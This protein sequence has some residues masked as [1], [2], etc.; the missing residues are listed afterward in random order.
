MFIAKPVARTLAVAA[1]LLA[2]SACDDKTTKTQEAQPSA[3]QAEVLKYNEYIAAANMTSANFG[4]QLAE[5]QKYTQPAF[6]GK[7]KMDDLFFTEPLS[8]RRIKEHLDK[9]HGMKPDMPELDEPGRLYSEALAK[10]EP[11][12][13][14]MY[15][16]ISAKTYKS[17]NGAHGREIQPA[18]LS[19]M[20]MLVVAQANF[21][22]G[23]EAK[24][25]ARIKA[26]FERTQ[27]GTLEH[28][29]MGMV[30]YLKE[31]LDAAG[32]VLDGKGLGDKKA[33]FKEAL[34]QFNSMATAYDAKVR[35]SNKTGCSSLLSKAN[36]YL[37]T[38][39][40]I[41]ERTE[42]GEYEKDAKQSTQF[43]LMQSQQTQDAQSLLQNYNNMVSAL[44]TNQC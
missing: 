31:S 10:A 32:G 14:D 18:L 16:Y 5:Y 34:D 37:S 19:S 2:L 28:A 15:N 40:D 3:E 11:V 38:G 22:E 20:Q 17:D 26:E 25:R 4:K 27:K 7:K 13:R 6:D 39:R 21:F 9:A 1:C 44:N 35:E 30:Y 41:I 29:Q 8:M 36:D 43:Q 33:A 12:S 24:D 23:I 42:N